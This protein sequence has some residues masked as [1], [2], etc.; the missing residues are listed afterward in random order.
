MEA[1]EEG[2]RRGQQDCNDIIR[3]WGFHPKSNEKTFMVVN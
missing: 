1:K 2:R 3:T